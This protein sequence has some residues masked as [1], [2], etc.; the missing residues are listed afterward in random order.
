MIPHFTLVIDM[1]AVEP[2]RNLGVGKVFIQIPLLLY[3]NIVI[4]N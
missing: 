3:G 2:I 4:N 1:A